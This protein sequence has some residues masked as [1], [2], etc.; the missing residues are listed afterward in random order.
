MWRKKISTRSSVNLFYRAN[1]N[2]IVTQLQD[3]VNNS[4]QFNLAQETLT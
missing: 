1:T 2:F 3:V 4:N